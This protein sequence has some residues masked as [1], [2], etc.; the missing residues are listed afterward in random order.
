MN[1]RRRNRQW[2]GRP[3]N[4]W[5][6]RCQMEV[7]HRSNTVV[8]RLAMSRYGEAAFQG[9]V[10]QCRTLTKSDTSQI[11]LICRHLPAT[12]NLRGERTQQCWPSGQTDRGPAKPEEEPS[13][14]EAAQP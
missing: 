9:E 14:A 7:S 11:L 5:R 12:V 4:R 3:R 1:R 13:A 2:R 6:H 10:W 8:V